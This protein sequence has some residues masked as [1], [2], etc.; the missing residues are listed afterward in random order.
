MIFSDHLLTIHVIKIIFKKFTFKNTENDL[1]FK[2][3]IL[4]NDW[5]HRTLKWQIHHKLS[6]YDLWTD[7]HLLK[8]HS[9]FMEVTI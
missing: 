1:I 5:G 4:K 6:L 8:S 9:S 3:L 7:Q 2:Y